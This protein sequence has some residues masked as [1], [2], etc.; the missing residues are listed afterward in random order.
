MTDVAILYEPDRQNL[1]EQY[2]AYQRMMDEVPPLKVADAPQ[3]GEKVQVLSF[4][5]QVGE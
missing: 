1:F 2:R 5:W 3:A 4:G